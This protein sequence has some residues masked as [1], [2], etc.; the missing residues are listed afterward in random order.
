MNGQEL[1]EYTR[2]TPAAPGPAPL[3]QATQVEQARAMAEVQ[4]AVWVA[5]QNPR[6]MDRAYGDMRDAC[7]HDGLAKRAFYS[8]PNRGTGS[9]VHLARELA[10]VWGNIRY[11]VRELHRDDAG[12]V[13]EVL[14]YAEDL[15]TNSRAERSF[16]V[17]HAKMVGK[18]ADKRR[19]ALVDLDDI[20]RNNQNTGAKAVRECIFGVLPN[21][22]ISEA[23]KIARKA[24]TGGDDGE[25]LTDRVLKTIA[26][27]SGMGV[28]KRRLELRQQKKSGQWSDADIAD[29]RIA[30]QT[31]SRN[32]STADQLFP[33]EQ[34]DAGAIPEAPPVK[35]A[36]DPW[37]NTALVA[38]LAQGSAQ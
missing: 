34:I 2:R 10:R 16:V 18:G 13:S 5:Q 7:S 25:T 26:T 37:Q 22:F 36:D 21:R 38:Q 3:S 29:L 9:T 32:E 35:P 30:Y 20:Y 11:G 12:G 28:S 4:A 19:E 15:Q 31:I 17:P 8:V 6:D 24:M 23:E 33:A 27:F 14:A 1:E